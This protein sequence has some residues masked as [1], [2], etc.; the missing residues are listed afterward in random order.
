[1]DCGLG[2]LAAYYLLAH[3]YE[4][5]VIDEIQDMWARS[6]TVDEFLDFLTPR[7]MAAA[8]VRYLWHLIGH[9]D[10]FG[11]TYCKCL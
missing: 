10:I 2:R 1:M 11:P 4:A 8:E 6:R 9:E 5:R 3:G 7:G